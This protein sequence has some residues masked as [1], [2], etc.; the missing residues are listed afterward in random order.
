MTSIFE[1]VILGIVQ[2]LT[3]WLPV[4]SSGHLAVAKEFINWQ[5]PVL[6]YVLLHLSTLFVILLFFR[7][8]L[9]LILK[10]FAMM[11]FRSVEGKLG[12]F[13]VVGSIPTAVFGY[14]FQNLFRTFY[15]NLIVVGFALMAT[16]LLLFFSGYKH[17]SRDLNYVDSLITGVAQG[18]AIIP[19]VSRSGVTISTEL[20]R[21]VDRK[22]AFEFSFLLSIPAVIGATFVELGDLNLLMANTEV[23]AILAGVVVAALVGYLSLRILLRTVMK[24]KLHWFAFYCWAASILIIGSQIVR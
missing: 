9:L 21:G 11:D 23:S 6:F 10:A 20:L 7:K 19:G 13:V 3:E 16:G 2:G 22:V 8:S 12:I 4:S 18:I 14:I 1:T 24:Q 15:N 17:G 5:P